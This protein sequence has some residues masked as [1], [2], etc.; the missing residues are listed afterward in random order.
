[1]IN[2]KEITVILLSTILMAFIISF[3]EKQFSLNMF[4]AGILIENPRKNH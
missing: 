1:M 2:Q 4:A 3:V